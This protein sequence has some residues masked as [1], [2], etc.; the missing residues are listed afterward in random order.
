V[1][2]T[3]TAGKNENNLSVAGVFTNGMLQTL[4]VLS[5]TDL[6]MYSSSV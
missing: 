5:K 1:E 3:E 4:V 6:D 2:K